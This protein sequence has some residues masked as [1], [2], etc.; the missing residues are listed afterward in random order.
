MVAQYESGCDI[1]WNIVIFACEDEDD[2]RQMFNKFNTNERDRTEAQILTATGFAKD[3]GITRTM[4]TAVF[5]AMPFIDAGFRTGKSSSDVLK[6]RIFDT[7][8]KSARAFSRQAKLLDECLKGGDS[9]I[10]KKLLGGGVTAVALVTLKN[11]EEIA[12]EFWRGVAKNDG[13]SKGDPRHTL[14]MD[15]LTR[16]MNSGA[17]HQSISAP[18]AAWN[19]FYAGRKLHHIKVLET[20]AVKIAGTPFAGA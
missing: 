2:L 18:A 16:A 8:I 11:Q 7:R 19:A 10:K 14:V 17:S 20:D 5:S 6:S 4:A 13:L 3:A 15:L 12:T 1:E 9:R